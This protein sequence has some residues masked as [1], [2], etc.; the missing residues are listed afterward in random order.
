MFFFNYKVTYCKIASRLTRH[1]FETLSV[2]DPFDMNAK[3][4]EENVIQKKI[5]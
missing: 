3:L 1:V 4:I 2:F 5:S